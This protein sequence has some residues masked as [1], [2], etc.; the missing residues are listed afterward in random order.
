MYAGAIKLVGTEA[1]VGVRLAGDVVAS[2]GDMQLDA[3]GHLSV[4]QVSASGAVKVK[5]ASVEVQGPMYS[6]TEVRV[7]S[8]GALVN[9]QSIAARERVTLQAEG[10]LSNR[11]V[12]EAGVNPDNTAV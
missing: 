4:A 3:N 7:D 5:A 11:G 12:I 1:G 8:A 10:T 9:Q 2:A 6:G